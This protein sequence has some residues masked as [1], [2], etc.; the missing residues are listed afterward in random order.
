VKA[1]VVAAANR[2]GIRFVTKPVAVATSNAMC[3]TIS[4]PKTVGFR[5]STGHAPRSQ[6]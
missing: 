1:G 4:C 6:P 3:M 2:R 5:R